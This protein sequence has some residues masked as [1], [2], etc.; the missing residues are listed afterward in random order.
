MAQA[1]ALKTI[2]ILIRDHVPENACIMG[3]FL[4]KGLKEI[5]KKIEDVVC[6][7]TEREE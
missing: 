1:A 7:R 4:T 6:G 5:Q 3:G 2:E